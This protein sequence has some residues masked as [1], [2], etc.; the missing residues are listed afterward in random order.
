MYCT[1]W[2]YAEAVKHTQVRSREDQRNGVSIFFKVLLL[3]VI[4]LDRVGVKVGCV[5]LLEP[6]FD[7]SDT[8]AGGHHVSHKEG[9]DKSLDPSFAQGTAHFVTKEHHQVNV[10]VVFWIVWVIRVDPARSKPPRK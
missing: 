1:Q 5:S 10:L 6:L 2:L 4:V 8:E 3:R 9:E 7:L